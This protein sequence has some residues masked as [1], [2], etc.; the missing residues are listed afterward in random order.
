[1]VASASARFA[2]G[3]LALTAWASCAERRPAPGEALA[4]AEPRAPLEAPHAAPSAPA[5]GAALP[6]APSAPSAAPPPA[7]AP[8]TVRLA[9]VGD[10]TVAH[11]VGD[12]LERQAKGLP[13]AKGVDEGFPFAG[14][15][16][17]LRAA[18]LAIGNMECVFSPV[19]VPS[20]W[21]AAFRAP[22]PALPALLDAGFDLL[23][24]ANNHSHDFGPRAFDDMVRRLDEAKLPGIGRQFKKLAEDQTPVIVTVKGIRLGFLAYEDVPTSRTTRDVALAKPQVDLLV[25]FNHWGNEGQPRHTLGQERL[26][27]AQLDAGAD[28]VVG[29]HAHVLQPLEVYKGKLLAYG[30]GN[31]VFSAMLHEEKFRRGGILEVEL[32]KKGLAGFRVWHTRIDDRGA[33][34]ALDLPPLTDAIS[35]N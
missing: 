20:T 1:M 11:L 32:T 21:H 34:R 35:S 19:G 27:R 6:A 2:L 29:A 10:V 31:F 24:V 5:S 22:P 16:D 3:A 28:L 7:S 33:P 17:R 9:F 25:V 15:R 8:D 12:Q 14:V 4:T 30:L 18:D 23:S 26:G 13:T